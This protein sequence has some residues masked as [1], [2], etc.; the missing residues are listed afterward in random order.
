MEQ[1][2]QETTATVPVKQGNR[3]V[4]LTLFCLASFVFFGLIILIFLAVLIHGN[5]IIDQIGR[6]HV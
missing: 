2:N 6:A 3:P 4:L 1:G 5:Y